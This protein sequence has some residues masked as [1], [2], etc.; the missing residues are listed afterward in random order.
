MLLSDWSGSAKMGPSAATTIRSSR[1]R[2]RASADG[3]TPDA[4]SCA[5]RSRS[6]RLPSTSVEPVADDC[7][8]GVGEHVDDR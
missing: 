3:R 1:S 5:S 7:K 2:E 8:Q 6:S 4:A